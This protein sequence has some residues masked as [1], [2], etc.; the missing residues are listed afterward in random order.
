MIQIYSGEHNAHQNQ[1]STHTPETLV[2][3]R[4]IAEQSKTLNALIAAVGV[5]F[6]ICL[7]PH[8][9]TNSD[10]MV[11]IAALLCSLI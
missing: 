11:R 2:S 9:C 8:V 6:H 7:M 3:Q 1:E 5:C 10:V 4:N